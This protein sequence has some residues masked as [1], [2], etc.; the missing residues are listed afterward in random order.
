VEVAGMKE[1]SLEEVLSVVSF[2]DEGGLT[3]V[4]IEDDR[5]LVLGRKLA[6]LIFLLQKIVIAVINK[7]TIK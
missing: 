3:E 6:E 4:S 5:A 7:I 1:V 2:E